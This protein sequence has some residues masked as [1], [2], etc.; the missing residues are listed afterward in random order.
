MARL[1]PYRFP[2][3]SWAGGTAHGIAFWH[4]PWSA[5]PGCHHASA[6]TARRPVSCKGRRPGPRHSTGMARPRGVG[7]WRHGPAPTVRDRRPYISQP[8]AP[9]IPN[10]N[11]SPTAQPQLVSPSPLTS[12]L[13]IRSA[14]V[15]HLELAGPAQVTSTPPRW[16]LL[17]L[18]PP[19][20]LLLLLR[21]TM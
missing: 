18:L 4:G 10:I 12:L 2:N 9:P 8:P 14:A 21:C 17:P 6:G 5:Q 15:V 20:L 11:H 7:R 19:F 13:S 16:P 1:N 3:S